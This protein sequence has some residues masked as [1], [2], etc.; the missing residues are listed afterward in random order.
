VTRSKHRLSG[1]EKIHNIIDDRGSDLSS[2]EER[3]PSVTTHKSNQRTSVP[4]NQISSY[5]ASGE[6]PNYNR[7]HVYMMTGNNE[8]IT[9]GENS[10]Y[11]GIAGG[12]SLVRADKGE[13][14]SFI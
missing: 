4:D 11:N 3:E 2:D 10:V 6:L 12:F 14:S 7:R 1:N 9:T 8:K 5:L 13:G